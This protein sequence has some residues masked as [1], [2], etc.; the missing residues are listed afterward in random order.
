[1]W[2]WIWFIV[3]MVLILFS[4][5]ICNMFCNVSS[6]FYVS[7]GESMAF[8]ISEGIQKVGMVLML[9]G[10]WY[11]FKKMNDEETS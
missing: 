11:I 4:S 10:G 6:V 8:A 1:M 9:L 7:I 2:N 5:V 3:G